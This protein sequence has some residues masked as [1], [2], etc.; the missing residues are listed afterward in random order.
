MQCVLS[1]LVSYSK[2][3]YHEGK[4]DFIL[5]VEPKSQRDWIRLIYEWTEIF[6]E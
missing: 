3:S 5:V 2:F 6:L 1:S 4:R